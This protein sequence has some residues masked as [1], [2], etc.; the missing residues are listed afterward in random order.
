MTA[1]LTPNEMALW[2]QR[3]VEELAADPFATEVNE[4]V[5]SYLC[6]KAGHPEWTI[7]SAPVDVKTIAIWM[8]RRTYTNPDQETSSNVG[9][10][11]SRV[12]DEAAL[13]MALTESEAATLAD[14][15]NKLGGSG[16]WR[17]SIG[18]A[19]T[20]LQPTVFVADTE[21]INLGLNQSWDVPFIDVNDPG[22]PL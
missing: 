4:K 9:P 10:L 7:E 22:G 17:S 21:Q 19:N 18:G 1:L 20:L 3:T 12:L 8:V 11:G 6:F 2:T 13:A 15:V 14:Y 16:L 5:G